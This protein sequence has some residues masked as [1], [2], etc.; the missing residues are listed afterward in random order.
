MKVAESNSTYG[1]RGNEARVFRPLSGA[2]QSAE[3]QR[4]GDEQIPAL[5]LEEIWHSNVSRTVWTSSGA[6]RLTES[7]DSPLST[8]MF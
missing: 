8:K 5:N 1:R 4:F 2:G 7:V 3:C 6:V